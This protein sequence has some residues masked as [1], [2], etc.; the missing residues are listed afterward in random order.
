MAKKDD[1]KAELTKLN[2]S[3]DPTATNAEL[4]ALLPAGNPVLQE[5]EDPIPAPVATPETDLTVDSLVINDPQVLL[6]KELPL[7]ITP[8]AGKDWT[9]PEQAAYAKILNAA[10]YANANWPIMKNVEVARLIEIGKDPSKYYLYTGT[11][12]GQTENLT[13]K[14]KLLGQE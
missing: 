7:V 5:P 10:A 1:L 9:N 2:I 4:E 6:P 11:Q 12:P 13:Y 8:P 14:N 3:F